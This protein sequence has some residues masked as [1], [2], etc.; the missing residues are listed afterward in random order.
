MSS[1][2]HKLGRQV[3]L[4]ISPLLPQTNDGP[5]QPPRSWADEGLSIFLELGVE[6]TGDVD[7]QTGLII[8]VTT[9][10]EKVRQFA[11]PAINKKISENF[12]QGKRIDLAETIRLLQ[13][14]WETLADKFNGAILNKL[15]LSTNPFRKI[16]ISREDKKM[17]Y[18][19][20]KFEFASTHKLWNNSFNE[21]L[22]FKIFG[23]C[24]NPAGH[25]HNYTAEIIV[26]IPAD[27]SD[28]NLGWFGEIIE[29]HFIKLVDHKNLNVDIPH[30]TKIVPTVENIAAF[31]W[32][33]LLD[34]FGAAKLHCVTIWETNRTYCSYYGDD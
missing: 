15:T 29:E 13:L 16:S 3:W 25:G 1:S 14:A 2:A 6:L 7:P 21:E 31:G 30:F 4:T 5:S 19:S 24:A 12:K 32:Q 26:K 9:I 20:E 34:K 27:R 18:L 8:N 28:L 33:K 10:D 22:N 11:I 17:I 23:K